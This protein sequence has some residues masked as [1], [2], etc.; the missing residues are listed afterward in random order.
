MAALLTETNHFA[1]KINK[2]VF[3]LAS[4]LI[5]KGG[6]L[7]TILKIIE[8]EKSPFLA[9]LVGR[10][11]AR[12]YTDESL[13]ISWSFLNQRD[14]QRT[15]NNNISTSS[16]YKLLKNVGTFIP[17]QNLY[18][19]IWQTIEGIK[20]MITTSEDKSR[21]YLMNF[22]EK[23]QAQ[24]QSRFFIIGPFENF[25]EAEKHLRQILQ[26]EINGVLKNYSKTTPEIIEETQILR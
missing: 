11:L 1:E 26:E 9:Q 3:S 15:N 12:T 21:E 24:P 6:D 25:S 18:V 16:L 13:G 23:L 22:A 10:A 19:L 17:S 8:K 5:E 14:L 2:E 4:L 7:K 20:A